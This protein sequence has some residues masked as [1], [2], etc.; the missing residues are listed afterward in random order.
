MK[1]IT[2]KRLEEA[3]HKLQ[4]ELI[5]EGNIMEA[6]KVNIVTNTLV[7]EPESMKRLCAILQEVWG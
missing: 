2:P 3:L 6:S 7:A 5:E 4:V 1:K